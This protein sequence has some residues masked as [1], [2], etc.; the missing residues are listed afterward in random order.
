[1]ERYD[2]I[3]TNALAAGQGSMA[4]ALSLKRVWLD[5]HPGITAMKPD[6]WEKLREVPNQVADAE[7]ALRRYLADDSDYYRD[8]NHPVWLF[9]KDLEKHAV[10][11]TTDR[12]DLFD[13]L[14]KYKKG[15]IN[16]Q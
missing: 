6:E 2:P 9:V 12:S 3:A 7:G 15:E 11:K 5:A 16:G 14:Q 8:K 4:K 13:F 10:E 1:M